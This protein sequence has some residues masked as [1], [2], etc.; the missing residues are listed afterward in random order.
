[1][2]GNSRAEDKPVQN[3]I[4]QSDDTCKTSHRV[5]THEERDS[6]T[7]APHHRSS[8]ELTGKLCHRVMALIRWR[9]GADRAVMD[10]IVWALGEW[11]HRRGI[12]IYTDLV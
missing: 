11:L 2:V 10:H 8:A 9:V 6:G 4:D 3:N 12:S 7:K 1:V 5:L